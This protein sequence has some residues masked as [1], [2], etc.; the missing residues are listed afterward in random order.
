[1]KLYIFVDTTSAFILELPE[2]K[3]PDIKYVTKDVLKAFREYSGKLIILGE[4]C[5]KYGIRTADNPAEDFQAIYNKAECVLPFK[6]DSSKAYIMSSPDSDTLFET[7]KSIADKAGLTDVEIIDNATGEKVRDVEYSYSEINCGKIIS[8]CNYNWDE[9][10][11]VSIYVNGEKLTEGML[12]L[13]T[14]EKLSE[15]VSLKSFEPVL[16]RAEEGM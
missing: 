16:I 8:I 12:E 11:N 5:F 9:D 6:A 10:K 13:K 14:G 15:S 4:E 7:I 3:F 2:Y 1:M